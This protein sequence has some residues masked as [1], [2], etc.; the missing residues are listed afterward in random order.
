MARQREI[1]ATLHAAKDAVGLSSVDREFSHQLAT[2]AADPE[3]AEIL[4]RYC[5]PPA[6][7]AA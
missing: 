6:L 5:R 2:N 7:G 4:R 1:E 3:I